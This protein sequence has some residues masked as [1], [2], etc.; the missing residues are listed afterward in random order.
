MA[1]I[2]AIASI[3]GL[4]AVGV[5]LSQTLYNIGSKIKDVKSNLNRI[6]THIVLFSSSLK[7]VGA[8]L[9]DNRS[10]H[11]PEAVGTAMQIVNECQSVFE[12][13][14]RMAQMAV[15][16]KG[17]DAEQEKA[18]GTIG[19]ND[20][21][22]RMSVLQRVRW[23]F[24]QPKVDCLL[25]QLEHL[26]TT[27]SLMIQTLNLAAVTL[28][29]KQTQSASE[30]NIEQINQER[31]HVETL[32]VARHLSL[33]VL[34]QAEKEAG[35]NGSDSP[36]SGS[37]AESENPDGTYGPKLLT[38]GASA[39]L[40][41][42]RHGMGELEF[43]DR[44][45]TTP[46][47][48]ISPLMHTSHTYVDELLCHWTR[49]SEKEVGLGIQTQHVDVDLEEQPMNG[50][51]ETPKTEREN[52]I[53]PQKDLV[54]PDL[55]LQHVEFPLDVYELPAVAAR[56]SS[57]HPVYPSNAHALSLDRLYPIPLAN[58]KITLSRS[59]STPNSEHPPKFQTF[60]YVP[61]SK[62]GIRHSATR[63][64]SYSYPYIAPPPI[65]TS[66]SQ[67]IHY[68]P[69]QVSRSISSFSPGSSRNSQPAL[70]F[71]P[72]CP[73]DPAHQPYVSS[74]TNSSPSSSRSASPLFDDERQ[75]SASGLGLGIPWR[76]RVSPTKYFDFLDAELVGPRT[77]YLPTEPISWV[78]SRE[79]AAT[80]VAS[81]WVCEEAI[82]ERRLMYSERSSEDGEWKGGYTWKE[83][84]SRDEEKFWRIN[85]PLKFVR[86]KS[87]F[88]PIYD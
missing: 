47:E 69:N 55:R 49:L 32:I 14:G 16:G 36:G 45:M 54:P 71:Y 26:K 87:T 31:M 62:A 73:K 65:S 56:T 40:S 19:A 88:T 34:G 39:S 33:I 82:R 41:L 35:M 30:Q 11:S 70:E 59:I 23:H 1:E 72:P 64:P 66:A 46:N 77:P 10:L 57:L 29:N 60:P 44:A 67:T 81:G 7:H 48:A 21:K 37:L 83:D 80:E 9:D 2:G 50:I 3:V 63:G 6:A 22:R 18:L 17:G 20:K 61:T 52:P 38:E 15:S 78:Y 79:H 76:I 74:P 25:A 53:Q 51:V 24:E 42:V 5:Q 84:A 28:K 75:T 43:L 8:V 13:I 27:L 86:E 12:E 68:L 58:T 4:A 85:R